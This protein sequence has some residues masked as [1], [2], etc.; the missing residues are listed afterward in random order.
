[1]ATKTKNYKLKTNAS[2]T[3]WVLIFCGRLGLGREFV[4]F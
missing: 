2:G 4:N 3:N 1:M